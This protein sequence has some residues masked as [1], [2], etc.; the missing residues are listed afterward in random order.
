MTALT[1]AARQEAWHTVNEVLGDTTGALDTLQRLA[2]LGVL[3][4]DPKSAAL[5][6]DAIY[7]IIEGLIPRIEDAHAAALRIGA[8]T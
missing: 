7:R 6:H 3:E 4:D 5:F 8:I 1:P 2:A